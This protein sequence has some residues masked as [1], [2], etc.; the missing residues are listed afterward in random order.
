MQPINTPQPNP[1]NPAV[2]AVK[3]DL[4]VGRYDVVMDTG[5]GYDTKRLES[6]E[7]MIDLLKTPLAEPIA[8]VGADL[9]VRNMD[10]AGASDLADRLMPMTPQGLEKTLQGLPKSAQGVVTAMSQ[11]MQQ[12]Q[13]KIQE[14]AMEIKYK[15]TIEHGW[16]QVEREKT[17]EKQTADA[18]NNAAKEF[19]THVKSITAR[20]VAEINAGAKLLD[21]HVKGA[22]AAR[23][24]E[25]AAA[26]KAEKSSL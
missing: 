23:K 4:T 13:Q 16:M 25:M 14:Q 1:E 5:P 7:T 6:A 20:D 21:T 8:K 26:E 11:H 2:M 22:H 19:D 12:L 3:N 9:V 18:A 10:F 17:K 15:T 24:D